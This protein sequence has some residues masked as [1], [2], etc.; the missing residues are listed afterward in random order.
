MSHDTNCRH[1][2]DKGGV[3]NGSQ[4]FLFASGFTAGHLLTSYLRC[5][6]FNVACKCFVYIIN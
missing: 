3:S 4:M 2:V 6:C 1:S 5:A